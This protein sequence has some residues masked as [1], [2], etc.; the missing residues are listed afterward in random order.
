M[1]KDYNYDVIYR[2]PDDNNEQYTFTSCK[3]FGSAEAAILNFEK[4]T[5]LNRNVITDCYRLIKGMDR[6]AYQNFVSK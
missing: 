2:N 5:G 3:W 1:R 4:V 6:P